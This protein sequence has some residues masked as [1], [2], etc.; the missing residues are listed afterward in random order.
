MA[1]ITRI[2][3]PVDF[4][5]GSKVALDYALVFADRFN[6]KLTLLHVWDVPQTLRP[7]LMV[8]LEGSDRQPVANIVSRQAEEE[9][10]AFLGQLPEAARSRIE[11]RNEQGE[12]VRT[13]LHVAKEERFDLLVLGTHGRSGIAHVLMGSVAERVVRQATCPVLTVR[14]ASPKGD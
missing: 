4:S 5:S 2:L 6:A 13:I 10:N 7:D 1:N 3:A 11:P 8:W 12:T 9:M 14:I